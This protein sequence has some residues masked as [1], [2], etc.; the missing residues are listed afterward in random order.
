MP[1]G[2]VAFDAD[3][4]TDVVG[5]LAVAPAL[6]AGDVKL[7]MSLARVMGPPDCQGDGTTVARY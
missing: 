5:D 2:D 1:R 6:D 7:R 3:L 4:A